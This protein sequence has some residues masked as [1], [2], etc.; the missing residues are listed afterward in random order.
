[1]L[2]RPGEPREIAT[3]ALF[4]A[5]SDSSYITGADLPVDGGSTAW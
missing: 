3:A 5:S 1:M 2:G 4:L